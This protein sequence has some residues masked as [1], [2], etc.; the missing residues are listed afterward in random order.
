MTLLT[1][2][3]DMTI[4]SMILHNWIIVLLAP[5]SKRPAGSEWRTTSSPEEVRNW[6][7]EGGNIGLFCGSAS[8][9]A[10]LD[11]DDT[12]AA[13]EMM[14]ELGPVPITVITGRSRWHTYMK[15]EDNLPPKIFWR[16]KVI[17]EVQRGPNQHVV[18]PPSLHP[19]TGLAYCW[20][21][22]NPPLILGLPEAWREHLLTE[23]MPAFIKKERLGQPEEEV[24]MGPNPDEILNR[25]RIVLT[26]GRSYRGGWKGQC[27]G[28]AKEGH[29]K[30]RDNAVVWSDGRWG[31]AVNRD[32]KKYI[33][34]ALGLCLVDDLAITDA[35][36]DALL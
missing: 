15:Y 11:F 29:D 9:V 31:C 4:S 24:W 30:H 36:L 32:H 5:R 22:D 26:G 28:C 34:E 1:T 27:P 10:V 19:D 33:G 16:G 7:E 14:L 6:V 2:Q 23:Y 20:T 13:T 35:E 17:G 3:L 21:V 12:E 18:M 25:A 8:Q